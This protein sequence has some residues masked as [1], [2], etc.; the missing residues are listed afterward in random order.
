MALD[1]KLKRN[2][3]SVHQETLH[4]YSLYL[5]RDRWEAE[6]LAQDTWLRV[7]SRDAADLE[8]H[9]NPEA[10]MLRIARNI[11]T[12][13]GRR[14][15]VLERIMNREFRHALPN[16]SVSPAAD[17]GLAAL[18]LMFGSLLKHLTPLQ[19]TVFML[20]DVYEYTARETAEMLAVSE[21][22]VKSA[23]HR[24]RRA[25]GE[26][27]RDLADDALEMP[28]EETWKAILRSIALAYE[29]GDIEAVVALLARDVHEPSAAVG[30]AQVRARYEA[31]LPRRAERE[32]PSRMAA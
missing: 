28:A 27:R 18:E 4:R 21:G 10:W 6:D 3:I 2:E 24:A 22:A 23:L 13:R 31:H 8:R 9:R 20:R 30:T 5:A 19:R 1:A 16:A 25:L 15:R 11:W 17:G 29:A 32:L 12:D 7:L 26:V 14:S